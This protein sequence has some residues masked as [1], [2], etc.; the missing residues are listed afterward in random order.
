M[1]TPRGPEKVLGLLLRVLP[2]R[3]TAIVAILALPTTLPAAD[4]WHLAGWKFR[5]V[6]SIPKPLADKTV[7]TA[8]VRVFCQGR[9]RADGA[10]FRVIDAA[11]KAV[12]FQAT[13]HD[14]DRY[15]WLAFRATTPAAG[16]RFY[17]YYGN[18]QATRAAEEVRASNKPG[19]GAPKGD[20]VPRH[21]LVFATIERPKGDNPKTVADLEKMLNASKDR[22]GARYQQRVSDSHNPFGPSDYY[23]S[24]YR[25]WIT[26]PKDATYRFCTAS[27]EASFSFLDGK[28]LVHWPG[29]HT[30]E[31]GG[32]GEFNVA[33][34]LTAGRHYLEYY[35]EE[36]MLKQVAFLGWS[37]PGSP[38]DHF[39]GIPA[40]RYPV[41]HA[42]AVT[43]YESTGGPIPV[44]EATMVDT[45]WP[46]PGV[47]SEGQYTRLHFA[48]SLP[49]TLPKGTTFG[50]DFG[51][52]QT[53]TGPAVD[54]VY[55]A[56][57]DYPVTLTAGN[58]T[59]AGSARIYEVA[60][61]TGEV[62][63]GRPPE[64]ASIA[65]GY[66]QQKL[67]LLNLTELVHLLA[68]SGR[69]TE[70]IVT[71]KL[72]VKRFAAAEPKLTSKVRRVMALAALETGEGG[73]DEAIANF[74]AS[75][76]DDTPTAEKID[77]FARLIR[78]LGIG[79]QQP[80]KTMPLLKQVEQTARNASPPLKEDEKGRLAYRRALNAA[81]DV[82]LWHGK[83]E[84]ARKF[85]KRVE[86]LRGYFIPSQVKAAR[87]GAFPNSIRDY[88]RL[89]NYGAALEI[90]DRWEDLFAAEKI[91]GQ[92]FFWRGKI[93]SMR[94]QSKP[95]AEF[96]DLAISLA[97]GAEFEN[98][99]RWRLAIALEQMGK[100]R[101]SREE[102]TKLVKTGL[103]DDWARLAREK[104]AK[105]APEKPK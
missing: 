51:D 50:W 21:G 27:N 46:D 79:R 20:W 30:S 57:G 55:L 105:A 40:A 103:N 63:Q 90:V 52:G 71:G 45:I 8:A 37:P 13:W 53:A 18:P 6:V 87:V 64:Y 74:Q 69:S 81:G 86:A 61:V 75:I 22:Y 11:G 14:H 48:V 88:L 98:E 36:V 96:L 70:A 47:R 39:Y 29:R 58:A 97:I 42:A 16:A 24:V 34:K 23:M 94:D 5:A 82:L 83:R 104:L 60:H 76:T 44:F 73:V 91:K 72:W 68:E 77:S 32:R 28:K 85:Y 38:K 2:F 62:R 54:H 80:E 26:I 95:A 65:L 25:G 92:T 41:P 31:R 1:S 101:R 84:E 7:D 78:L 59:V 3:L 10:D 4:A 89:N 93:F 56:L 67:D 49:D 100:T 15:A 19:A 12:P 17:V 35:H 66:D 43:G 99:A 9:G 102:L 33:V